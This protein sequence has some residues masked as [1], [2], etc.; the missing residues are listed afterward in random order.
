MNE[1]MGHPGPRDTG[2]SFSCR[3]YAEHLTRHSA[4]T[5][6]SLGDFSRSADHENE[7][8]DTHAYTVYITS[9]SSPNA[10]ASITSSTRKIILTT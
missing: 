2:T 7:R 4:S 10:E 3:H 6:A 8:P 1:P 5:H 9:Y